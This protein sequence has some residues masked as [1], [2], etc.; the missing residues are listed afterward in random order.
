MQFL[1]LLVMFKVLILQR[2]INTWQ[3]KG[4]ECESKHRCLK[5]GS[6]RLPS[7]VISAS[8]FFKSETVA[9]FQTEVCR[10][11]LLSFLFR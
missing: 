4:L 9:W 6:Q 8:L 11:C 1:S 5:F 10:P 7:L 3:D 2:N